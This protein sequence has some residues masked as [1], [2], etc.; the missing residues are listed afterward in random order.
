MPLKCERWNK[1]KKVLVATGVG[2]P[3]ALQLFANL[4]DVIASNSTAFEGTNAKESYTALSTKLG[5]LGFDVLINDKK[6]SEFI[7]STRLGEVVGQRDQFKGK[8]EE[9]TA[10]LVKL[11]KGAGDNDALKSQYQSLIDQNNGLLKELEQTRVNAEIMLAAKDA[12]N[13]KDLLVFIN[14]DAIKINAKGDILGVEGEVARLKSEKPYLFAN[15]SSGNKGGMDTSGDKGSESK[16]T[17]MN[18]AIR[19]AAGKTF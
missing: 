15:P 16:L 13:A 1:M 10:E 17:G 8:V 3:L 14:H 18:A 4:D 5:E 12:I 19:R 9:L 11:Q 7:P 2:K 6:K